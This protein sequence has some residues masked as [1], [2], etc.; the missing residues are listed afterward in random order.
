MVDP[1]IQPLQLIFALNTRIVKCLQLQPE[2]IDQETERNEFLFLR[3]LKGLRFDLVQE[4]L[5]LGHQFPPGN[6]F[7]GFFP[8]D[9]LSEDRDDCRLQHQDRAKYCGKPLHIISIGVY[10]QNSKKMS[11]MSQPTREEIRQ[12][13]LELARNRG[14]E[15]TLCPSEVVR[16]LTDDWRPLM[17]LV[18]EVAADEADAG[19]IEVTQKGKV[20]DP[21]KANGP[22]RLGLK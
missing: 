20:V 22:I 17:D 19:R 11:H 7:I 13:M 12:K 2:F 4:G 3:I 9:F 6:N 5:Q 8:L 21:L 15:K 10:R 18:R 14:S 1:L 16:A